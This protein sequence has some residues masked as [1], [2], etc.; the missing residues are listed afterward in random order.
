M[1]GQLFSSVLQSFTKPTSIL[2]VQNTLH[3]WYFN[4]CLVLSILNGLTSWDCLNSYF[5]S[6]LIHSFSTVTW[7]QVAFHELS[8]AYGQ[9][10]WQFLSQ[11]RNKYNAH[12]VAICLIVNNLPTTNTSQI[13]FAHLSYKYMLYVFF[14][15]FCNFFSL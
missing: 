4:I 11:K 2:S 6:F 15:I 8:I 14:Q 9:Q 5:H 12:F 1:L 10:P 3:D 13:P 7:P